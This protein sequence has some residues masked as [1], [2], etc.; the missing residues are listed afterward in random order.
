MRTMVTLACSWC[1]A[2][3]QRIKA[4]ADQAARRG[5]R[6]YCSPECLSKSL[7]DHLRRLP[8]R[9]VADRFWSKVD[10]ADDC[11]IWTGGKTYGGYGVFCLDGQMRR[12]HRIAWIITNGPIPDGME[13]L[14]RCD[15]PPCVNPAH[16]C[17]GTHQDNM[18]DMARKG[19]GNH[20]GTR[21]EQN[22]KARL[23]TRDIRLIREMVGSGMTH[24]AAAR[25]FGVARTTVTAIIRGVNWKHVPR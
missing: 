13:V 12:A 11:W 20:F 3:F 23:T 9:S 25:Q 6:S 7:S 17:L 1:G 2:S 15:N 14:H 8:R 21:G 10:K 5:Y 24:K 18:D 16:L 4:T 19:R 22:G